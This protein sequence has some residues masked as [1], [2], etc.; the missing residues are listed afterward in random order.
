ML[1]SWEYDGKIPSSDFTIL[2]YPINFYNP[3]NDGYSL[4]PT[5]VGNLH[6]WCVEIPRRQ[7]R[8]HRSTSTGSEVANL[9]TS[10]SP[11]VST[12]VLARKNREDQ[13]FFRTKYQRFEPPEVYQGLYRKM[14]EFWGGKSSVNFVRV[15]VLQ[16]DGAWSR[17]N[18]FGCE[19]RMQILP[20]RIQVQ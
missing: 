3:Q 14:N 9:G 13:W 5:F 10:C 19:A 4:I 16:H 7:R 17:R 1:I 6:F 2:Q 20:A 11:W 12:Y 18:R 8:E 15:S